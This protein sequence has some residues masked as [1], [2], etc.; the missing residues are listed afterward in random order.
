MKYFFINKNLPNEIKR[1]LSFFGECIPLPELKKLPFP[2]SLHPDML[3]AEVGGNLFIHEEYQEGQTLLSSLGIPFFISH[4][5]V[6]EKYPGD[7]RLNCFC[8]G[9]YFV[10]NE[11]YISAEALRF[12][13]QTGFC[14]VSVSQGYAKCS[15]AIAGGTLA[16]AD[17]GI[18]KALR[19]AG[20]DVLLLEPYSIGI[21]IYN[22]GFIGGASV[23]LD[24]QTLGFFGNIEAFGQYEALRDFFCCHGI[25]LVSLS[26]TPL[27]DYGG[28]VSFSL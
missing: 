1:N 23:L 22:T 28:A 18:E 24:E 11:K 27:F 17:R 12:A 10:S 4:T 9:N 3:I 6:F 14:P 7:I 26:D 21:D 25:S 15:C 2:V 8:M 20:A 5:P 19:K 16:T 13:K